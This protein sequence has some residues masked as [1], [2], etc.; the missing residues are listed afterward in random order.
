MKKR[1]SEIW[2]V[3]LGTG[4]IVLAV[5][6]LR[7]KRTGNKNGGDKM[8]VYYKLMH[9]WMKL[10]EENKSVS[11]YMERHGFHTV[12]IYGLG[13]IGKHLAWELRNASTAVAYAIDRG[14]AY[15]TMDIDVYAPE[16]KLPPVDAVLVTPVMEY[17]DICST[18]KEKVSC[19]VLSILEVIDELTEDM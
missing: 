15:L 7:E 1:I 9:K 5:K 17:E 14:G 8:S 16:S 2:S 11:D 6:L 13:D 4:V 18:L 12:A 10:R 19:P 3:L